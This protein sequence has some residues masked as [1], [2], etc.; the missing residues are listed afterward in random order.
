MV[1]GAY[2]GAG[3]RESG[4]QGCTGAAAGGNERAGRSL[5]GIFWRSPA[6]GPVVAERTRHW[7][8]SGSVVEQTVSWVHVL[9]ALV[10]VAP[11]DV[12]RLGLIGQW[13]G[14]TCANST[15]AYDLTLGLG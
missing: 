7:D 13:D 2:D 4:E 10:P 12:Q 5:L 11:A 15:F 6:S 8:E 1:A 9:K 3:R 14:G